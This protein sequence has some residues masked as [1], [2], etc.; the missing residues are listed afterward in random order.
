MCWAALS[1]AE[2][3]GDPEGEETAVVEGSEAGAFTPTG[4]GRLC[5]L[6]AGGLPL[7]PPCH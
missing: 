6:E 4:S 7:A 3:Q 5:R 1:E 2:E